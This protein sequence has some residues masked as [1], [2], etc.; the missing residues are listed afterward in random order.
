[1]SDPAISAAHCLLLTCSPALAQ[2]VSRGCV[3]LN[4]AQ[5][6]TIQSKEL[7]SKDLCTRDGKVISLLNVRNSQGWEGKIV[8]PYN[9][10]TMK[11]KG[12]PTE[13]DVTL[14]TPSATYWIH[15]KP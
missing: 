4:P 1:M 12:Q 2:V 14:Q 10:A 5:T 8:P 7:V 11:A 15:I 3:I 9:R 6:N 13:A